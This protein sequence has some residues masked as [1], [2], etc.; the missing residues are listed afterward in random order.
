MTMPSTSWQNFKTNV[1]QHRVINYPRGRILGGC[2]SING[3]IY[4]QGNASDYNNW[5]S[6]DWNAPEMFEVFDR[7]RLESNWPCVEQRLSWSI[8]SSFKDAVEEIHPTT[9]KE[10]NL[11]GDGLFIDSSVECCGFFRVNQRK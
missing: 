9:N 11:S 7:I 6:K 10:R 2:S 3:M 8:L 5:G 1:G 4:Q